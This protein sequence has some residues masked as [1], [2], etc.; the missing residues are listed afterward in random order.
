MRSLPL[1]HGSR[2]R[3]RGSLV[4][5][6]FLFLLATAAAHAQAGAAPGASALKPPPG[7]R[8]AIVEWDD[9]QCPA[10]ANANPILRQAAA[11]YGIPW[12]RHDLLIPYHNWS[13]SAAVNARWF[14]TKSSAL[15]NQYRDE[16]FA[17][18]T[19]IFNPLMLHQFTTKFAGSHGIAMPFDVDPQ[20]KLLAE[21]RADSELGLHS[22]VTLTPTIYV[23]SSSKKTPFVQVKDPDRDLYHAIDQALAETANEKPPGKPAP[24]AH[25]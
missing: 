20:G 15:G 10:C 17:N 8:V 21:V 25:K 24:A 6:V 12:I 16:V 18:Q 19:S 4:S 7:V 9:L 14:D 3:L 5:A 22:G 1:L 11:K 23:V 13:Q 2:A